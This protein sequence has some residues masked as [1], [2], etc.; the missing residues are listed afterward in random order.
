MSTNTNN[1]PIDLIKL[2]ISISNLKIK[3]RQQGLCLMRKIISNI[4]ANPQNEKYHSLN[5]IMLQKKLPN[6][7]FWM[8]LLVHAGFNKSQCGNLW[9]FNM[10]KL[11]ELS[12]I[13]Y[14]ITE[15]IDCM[16]NDKEFN[17]EKAKWKE[18]SAI[19]Q[20]IRDTNPLCICGKVLTKVNQAS[21]VY[22]GNSV[23]C[24]K[25]FKMVNDIDIIWHCDDNF[26]IVHPDG[27][28]ICN[29]CLFLPTADIV[30]ECTMSAS[31]CLSANRLIKAI[32]NYNKNKLIKDRDTITCVTVIND[33]LHVVYQHS[34]DTHFEC[35]FETLEA[36]SHLQCPMFARNYGNKQTLKFT[37]RNDVVFNEI[38]DT[39]HCYFCHC[40]DV[41]NR[42]FSKQKAILQPKRSHFRNAI[43]QQRYSRFNELWYNVE[44]NNQMYEFGTNFQYTECSP[45]L[46]NYEHH[47]SVSPRYSNLKQELVNNEISIEQFSKT[48]QKACIFISCK[49]KKA[50][51]EWDLMNIEYIVLLST[52]CNFTTFQQK[53]KQTYRTNHNKL[54][55][56]FYWSGKYLKKTVDDFGKE[57]TYTTQLQSFYHGMNE[58]LKFPLNGIH[59]YSPLSISTSIVAAKNFANN[60]LVM[61]LVIEDTCTTAKYFS[62]AWLS[63]DA[64]ECEY[65]ISHIQP[66]LLM[67]PFRIKNVIDAETGFQYD[68]FLHSLKTISSILYHDNQKL[69]IKPAMRI[70]RMASNI[71]LHQLSVEKIQ[72]FNA[73]CEIMCNSFFQTIK[74][75]YF[76][77]EEV[78]D[79]FKILFVRIH[80]YG[81]YDLQ[82]LH[83]LFPQLEVVEVLNVHLCSQIIDSIFQYAQLTGNKTSLKRINVYAVS[84]SELSPQDAVTKY[85]EKFRGEKIFI[86]GN[87]VDHRLYILYDSN[88]DDIASFLF[89]NVEQNLYFIDIK[90]EIKNEMSKIFQNQSLNLLQKEEVIIDWRS[91]SSNS[92]SFLSELFCDIQHKSVKIENIMNVFPYIRNI[93]IDMHSNMLSSFMLDNILGFLKNHNNTSLWGITIGTGHTINV[94]I[95]KYKFQFAIL[96]FSICGE[97][98]RLIIEKTSHSAVVLGINNIL[99]QS[100]NN[101][102]MT[103]PQL[104]SLNKQLFSNEPLLSQT[105]KN[106]ISC[107]N[108]PT[109]SKNNSNTSPNQSKNT[110][111]TSNNNNSASNCNNGNSFGGDGSGGDDRK[112]DGDE[113]DKNNKNNKD[114]S[115]SKTKKKKK[116]KHK[117]KKKKPENTEHVNCDND[118]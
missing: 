88:T 27:F 42:L 28:D 66:M 16:I 38:M 8:D 3:Q 92:D 63:N 97:S 11:H 44:A 32:Q 25:C 13:F 17:E 46:S 98:N 118:A 15:K 117:K 18:Q 110:D 54:H 86:C 4:L 89:D 9:V 82:L 41:G 36:C 78:H 56:N 45:Q 90:N 20:V 72:Y 52:Y 93:H 70:K 59:I 19:T 34:S 57:I 100:L 26:N 80:N 2:L 65:L 105:T 107:M 95:E 10:A 91:I 101:I 94:W 99:D 55:D 77:S 74:Y 37:D 60:G 43:N 47:I 103:K 23:C 87:L 96:G 112:R 5:A 30:V 58:K 14:S 81:W 39:I 21:I 7:T 48:Y 1:D 53:L 111:N 22:E 108:Y 76:D 40:Y 64:N 68:I 6:G 49:Y 29:S 35:M 33:Y 12:N 67:K 51:I 71:I 106:A 109:S 114:N 104:T 75:A 84:S 85:S 116:K 69:V 24:D 31:E 83:A 73:Y 102:T 79:I 115:K 113:K 61:E 50:Q 62:M